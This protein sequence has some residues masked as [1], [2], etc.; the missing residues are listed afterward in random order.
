M[1]EKHSQHLK[2]HMR[3]RGARKKKASA[4][5][6]SASE[7]EMKLEAKKTRERSQAI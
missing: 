4:R 3:L 1:A 2:Q 5:N 7:S 6:S